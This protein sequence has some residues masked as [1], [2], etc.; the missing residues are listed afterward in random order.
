MGSYATLDESD[1]GIHTGSD[2][3]APTSVDIDD[4]V[5]ADVVACHRKGKS[6]VV[7]ESEDNEDEDEDDMD[8]D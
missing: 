3:G 2:T 6:T 8:E 1:D 7:E 5:I 4:E